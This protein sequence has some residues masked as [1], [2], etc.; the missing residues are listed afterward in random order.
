MGTYWGC[1]TNNVILCHGQVTLV[2]HLIIGIQFCMAHG[3]N[4]AVGDWNGTERNGSMPTGI[5][6]N[7]P[8]GSAN[9]SSNVAPDCDDIV[10][11]SYYIIYI[12]LYDILSPINTLKLSWCFELDMGRNAGCVLLAIKFVGWQQK[13]SGMPSKKK[14]TSCPNQLSSSNINKR[15]TWGYIMF[16]PYYIF[17]NWLVLY[18]YIIFCWWKNKLSRSQFFP[19]LN[20]HCGW[21]CSP[22]CAG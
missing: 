14:K 17:I 5:R 12:L 1:I 18:P 8:H 22:M 15:C 11:I 6:E 20:P 13:K 19:Q 2:I 21:F 16:F 10:T 7:T 3:G 4:V 9:W